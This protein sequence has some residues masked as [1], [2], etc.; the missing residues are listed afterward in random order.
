MVTTDGRAGCTEPSVADS[1][2]RLLVLNIDPDDGKGGQ[3]GQ[4]SAHH[5]GSMFISCQRSTAETSALFSTALKH[6]YEFI[7]DI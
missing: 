3:R 5:I 2:H 1:G 4:Q 7:R 6:K